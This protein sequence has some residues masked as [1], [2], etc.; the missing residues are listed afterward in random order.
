ME[1][2]LTYQYIVSKGVAKGE[3]REAK[4]ILL[5]HGHK[6]FGPPDPQTMTAIDVLVDLDH[7]EQLIDRILEVSSWQELLATLPT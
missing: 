6:R 7:L 5:R 1:E 4:K 2:S 3:L